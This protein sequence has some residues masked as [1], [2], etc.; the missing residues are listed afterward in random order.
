MSS[1]HALASLRELW[2]RTT[3]H[4]ACHFVLGPGTEKGAVVPC[5]TT[6]LLYGLLRSRRFAPPPSTNILEPTAFLA[7]PNP[8]RPRFQLYFTLPDT[9]VRA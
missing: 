4:V 3:E 1:I 7:A 6:V 2:M 9:C 5:R 8:P